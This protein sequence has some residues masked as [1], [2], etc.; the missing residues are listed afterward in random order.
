MLNYNAIIINGQNLHSD[1]IDYTPNLL[2]LF[3]IKK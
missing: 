2:Y 3:H 1:N